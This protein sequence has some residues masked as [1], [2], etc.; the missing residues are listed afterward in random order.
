[1]TAVIKALQ[2]LKQPCKINLYSDSAYVVNAFQQNWVENWIKSNWKGTNKKPVKNV[3]LWQELLLLISHHDITFIKVKGH[4]DNKYN[5][6]CDKLARGE[7]D[8]WL[9]DHPDF[10]QETSE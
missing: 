5:N 3:D 10:K 4:A 1:M 2:Q 8:K 9:A 7:V 6:I